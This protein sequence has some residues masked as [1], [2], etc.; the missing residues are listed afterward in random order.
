MVLQK[1]V[2][3]NRRV[4]NLKAPAL[5]VISLAFFVVGGVYVAERPLSV[6]WI[7]ASVLF[8]IGYQWVYSFMLNKNMYTL[9]VGEA[10]YAN[11]DKFK[12]LRI[13][14]FCIGLVIC[15]ASTFF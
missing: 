6:A 1:N 11:S 4:N 3:I 14:H 8:L 10:L 13:F 15:S 5:V 2:M 7:W 9:G 12:P